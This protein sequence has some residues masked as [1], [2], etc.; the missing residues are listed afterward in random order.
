MGGCETNTAVSHRRADHMGP[1]GRVARRPPA[2]SLPLLLP[3]LSSSGSSLVRLRPQLA[4]ET[5]GLSH[6]GRRLFS[7]LREDS[8]W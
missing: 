3:L 4:R 5:V 8:P 6:F 1:R 7:L 2:W